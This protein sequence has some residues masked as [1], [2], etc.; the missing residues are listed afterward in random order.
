MTASKELLS[1][2][3]EWRLYLEGVL[4]VVQAVDPDVVLQGGAGDRAKDGQLQTFGGCLA[5][6]LAH[7]AVGP[8]SLCQDVTCLL[9]HLDVVGRGEV[10]LADHNNIL[11]T[12]EHPSMWH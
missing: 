6:R 4:C 2:S 1:C 12:P 5:D 10:L 9:I 7:K 11:E 3:P 8:Q